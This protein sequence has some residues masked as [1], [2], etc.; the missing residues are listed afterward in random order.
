TVFVVNQYQDATG[1]SRGRTLQARGG[2]NW[3]HG[4]WSGNVS[5]Y[6]DGFIGDNPVAP[7]NYTVIADTTGT[8]AGDSTL[9]VNNVDVT[10]NGSPVGN[11]G[12]LGLVGGGGFAEYSDAD[13]AEVVVYNRVLSDTELTDVRNFLYSKYDSPAWPP[14]PPMATVN[15]GEIATFTGGDAGEGLDLAGNFAYAI[16][17]GGPGGNVVG[18]ATF[19]DGSEAGMA[20]GSSAGASITDANEILEWHPDGEYGDTADDDNLEAV[21]TSIRWNQ[22]PGLDIDLNVEAGQEYK[23]QLLFAESCCDRGFD[24]SIEGEVGVDNF[25]I[26]RTQGGINNGAMGVVYSHSFTASDDVLNINLGGVNIDAGDNN[27][28]LN[29]LTLEVVPEP[30]GLSLILLGLLGILTRRRR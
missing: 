13:I 23:L 11:P 8:P 3:L 25:N 15:F 22:P 17:V 24:I 26:Q 27:P 18:T 12:Q 29:G 16:N 7:F 4:L 1:I 21:M 9:F 20:G 10:T 14:P 30:S 19:S 2:A 6:A 28:I 5:S